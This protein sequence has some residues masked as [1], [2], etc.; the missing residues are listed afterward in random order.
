LFKDTNPSYHEYL[1]TCPHSKTKEEYDMPVSDNSEIKL[2]Y[3]YYDNKSPVEI[4]EPKCNFVWVHYTCSI[5]VP[6]CY[7]E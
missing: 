4:D 2:F 7:F 6:E 1:K 3:D 5:W